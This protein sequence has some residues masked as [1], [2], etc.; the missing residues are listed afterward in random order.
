MH[1]KSIKPQSGSSQRSS[2]LSNLDLKAAYEAALKAVQ[3]GR[4]CLLDYFGKN[5][6]VQT[7]DKAGLVSDADRKCEELMKKILKEHC[8]E[9]DFLGEE[10]SYSEATHQ[11]EKSKK[12]RWIL[13]PLD[14]TTNYLHQLPIWCISLALEVDE[15]MQ[16]GIIDVP[17]LNQTFTAQ[18][19]QGAFCNGQ[20][21]K[22]SD[23]ADL[24]D[25]FMTTGFVND[26]QEVLSQQL[27]IFDHFVWKTQAIRR[28][29]AA[30]YD[31]AMVAAGNF[32]LYWERNIQPWDVAAGI[33][34]VEEAGGI[35]VNY[36]GGKYDAY[37][38]TIV[39]S[40]LNLSEKFISDLKKIT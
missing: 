38:K 17:L 22:V 5:H 10:T 15:E 26:Y 8:P 4:A 33:L 12:P 35:C 31:L 28:P 27:K 20:P 30:A 36:S 32:D 16:I 37:Q 11:F 29:G 9:F 34:L 2:S 40:N 7:K 13:D 39:A 6:N 14:G 3:S 19:G 24:K 18:R 1:S 25:A 21:L 23:C